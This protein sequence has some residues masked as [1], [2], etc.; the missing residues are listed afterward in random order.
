MTRYGAMQGEG[1]MMGQFLPPTAILFLSMESLMSQFFVVDFQWGELWKA[2][3]YTCQ[4]V[5]ASNW[6]HMLVY[7]AHSSVY[8]YLGS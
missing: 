8:Y 4:N 6:P 5:V 1:Q 3:G 2:W 7:R